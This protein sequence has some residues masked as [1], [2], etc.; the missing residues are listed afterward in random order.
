IIQGVLIERRSIQSMVMIAQ[1]ISML[2]VSSDGK[3]LKNALNPEAY[4]ILTVDDPGKAME[5]LHDSEYDMIVLHD[6]IFGSDMVGVVREIRRRFPLTPVLVLSENKDS[7]YQTDLMEAGAT[8]LLGDD[9][10]EEELH[11]RFRLVLQ[12]R[13]QNRALAR[14]NANLQDL[15][16]LARRLH[17]AN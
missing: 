8:D 17:T 12:Q 7:A 3:K 15:T 11:R 14:R 10:Y 16:T 4:D 2:L 6:V 5:M 9:L 1:P 13:R